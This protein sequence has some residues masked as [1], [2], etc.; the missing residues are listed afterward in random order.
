MRV[1]T[2]ASTKG[3]VGKSTLAA[4]CADGLLREGARVQLI[5]LDPQGTLTKWAEP[6]AQRSPALLTSRMAPIAGASFAQ[7]YNALITIL[8]DETDWVIIDT[9][10]SDDVRQLAALAIC[11]LVISPSGP[12]EAEVMGVQKTLRYLETALQ[13]IGSTVPPMDMLRVVYQRPNGFPN[14]EMLVMR[15]LIY[16]HFGAV[17]AI[18]QSAAIMSFLGRRMTTAEAI[19]AGSDAA[20]FLKMQAAADKLTQ[21]L[22]GQFDV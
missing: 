18:H 20:P 11:D 22:R 21:S 16:D 5:D 7:H 19:T 15:E 2:F 3:G 12:V 14:A 9:A 13:E 10:G 8:E 1:I 4:L 17:D 6:I